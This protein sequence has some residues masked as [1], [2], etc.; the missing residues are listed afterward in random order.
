MLW[1][2]GLSGNN[3]IHASIIYSMLIHPFL[4]LSES[5]C[6]YCIYFKVVCFHNWFV[7]VT[8]RKQPNSLRTSRTST[9]SL[10]NARNGKQ[11]PISL[12]LGSRE[13]VLKE[14]SNCSHMRH[15]VTMSMLCH[16]CFR[17]P[18]T[19]CRWS[20]HPRCLRSALCC[21]SYLIY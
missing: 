1:R 5:L 14:H 4:L 21:R 9:E 18:S 20:S 8:I 19:R 11:K 12:S 16:L 15:R 17:T 3:K 2:L 7:R 10:G 6:I 13:L